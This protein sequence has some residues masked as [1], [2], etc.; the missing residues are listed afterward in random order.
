MALV[1]GIVDV[2]LCEAA[3]DEGS[4]ELVLCFGD[5][6]L[7]GGLDASIEVC[8]PVIWRLACWVCDWGSV[9]G[10]K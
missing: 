5:H 1:A 6:V 9:V 10:A 8:L 2:A 7:V 3:G 4:F